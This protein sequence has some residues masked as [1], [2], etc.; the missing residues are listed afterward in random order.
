MKVV[1]KTWGSVL[2]WLQ[3]I[4]LFTP[5]AWL[6]LAINPFW[7]DS[8]AYSQV[9]L[10]PGPMTILQFSPLYCFGARIPLYV[11]CAYEALVARGNFP[12][13]A[14]F[15]SPT[16]TDTG[17]LLLVA[18]QHLFLLA[19]Q[20]FFLRSIAATNFTKTILAVL[21]ALNASF[22]TYTHCVGAEA[23]AL[24]ATLLVIGGVL[25]L[26]RRHHLERSDW[27]WF[28]LSLVL[29]VLTRHIN[30]VLA[31]LLPAVFLVQAATEMTH[32][33]LRRSRAR[34][35][36]RTIKRRLLLGG[37]S[38][39]VAMLSLAV[40]QR[41]VLR[42]CRAA[43]IK[44][45]STVGI[46]FVYRLNFLAELD[47]KERTGML[48]RVQEK[49]RDPAVQRMIA[50]TPAGILASREW[51]PGPCLNRFVEIIEESGIKTDFAYHLDFYAN[52]VASAF[53]R[54]FE[55]SFLRAVRADFISSFDYSVR[56]STIFPIA[57]TRYCLTR[58]DEMPQLAKLAT[59]RGNS[60]DATLGAQ[61]QL[62]YFRLIDVR[63]RNLLIAWAA[64]IAVALVVRT[65][66][67]IV[68]HSAVL[69]ATGVMM[70][71]LT[72]SLTYLLP[73]FL[74]PFW[75]CYVAA[76]LLPVGWVLDEIGRRTLRHGGAPPPTSWNS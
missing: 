40:A 2:K 41:S 25:R 46:T 11:G 5:S 55:P 76:V 73:R 24:S 1:P 63:F 27:V 51:D 9:T 72:C 57:T 4:I 13:L 58:L 62:A 64:L 39:A 67:R 60:V 61:E 32:A 56:D 53:L 20:L 34:F 19:A 22:Y 65:G 59:F 16:L 30:A 26:S 48:E 45:R 66:R 43:K 36:R 54:S 28:G 8:D 29:C 71:L 31:L 33:R 18:L 35:P 69:V 49:T 70:V 15:H 50:A 68:G 52:R 6:L 14:F 3:A 23:V 42:V 7:R 74:L 44:Y 75:V 47:E 12:T 21:L 37:L 38:L 10:P 17:V